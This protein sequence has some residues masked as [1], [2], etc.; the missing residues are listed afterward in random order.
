MAQLSTV[1]L[2]KF[3][4]PLPDGT[5]VSHQWKAWV[6]TDGLVRWSLRCFV[7]AQHLPGYKKASFDLA[8]WLS[9][10]RAMLKAL[11]EQHGETYDSS[12]FDSRLAAQRKD[13]AAA[14]GDNKAEYTC[15]SKALLAML[16]WWSQAKQKHAEKSLAKALCEGFLAES[17]PAAVDFGGEL[18]A[19]L[20]DVEASCQ[21]APL[22]GGRCCHLQE[23]IVGLG[24]NLCTSPAAVATSIMSA[25]IRGHPACQAISELR[26]EFCNDVVDKV[27][28]QLHT[29]KFHA[30][31]QELEPGASGQKKRR[32]VDEDWK[33]HIINKAMRHG[34]AKSG[35]QLLKAGAKVHP[36]VAPHWMK[37]FPLTY[38]AA[39]WRLLKDARYLALTSDGARLGDP[40]E[41]AI[42]FFA[43]GL[44]QDVGVVLPPQVIRRETSFN[45]VAVI[46]SFAINGFAPQG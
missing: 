42:L 20:P 30:D 28:M 22:A 17:L 37:E 19:M 12:I 45:M 11:L 8:S 3:A 18:Q 1:S 24:A 6:N 32:R 46:S 26:L 38:Q 36:N 43:H 41:E 40:P 13:D 9:R 10:N 35:Q 25:L 5:F 15:T 33:D 44:E 16:V 7:E 23:L 31:L 29:G 2:V 27:D 39:S 14:P 4:R 34:L 21:A